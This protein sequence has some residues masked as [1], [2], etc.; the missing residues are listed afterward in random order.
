MRPVLLMAG[1]ISVLGSV[2]AIGAAAPDA[3]APPPGAQVAAAAAQGGR[4]VPGA[5]L[6]ATYCAGCH[7]VDLAGGRA[8]SLFTEKWL[9]AV[10][11][12]QMLAALENG[13]PGTEM[14]SF[15]QN[16]NEAERWQIVQYIRTQA[17]ALA[18]KPAF[19]ADPS[20][21]L[22]RAGREQ[23]KVEVVARDLETPWALAFLPDGRLLVTERPGR[24]RILS[25]GTLSAP[26]AGTPSVHVQQDGGLFDVEVHPLYRANGWIYL[27]YSEVRPGFVP[28]PPGAA[29][30][31][32]APGRGGRGPVIPSMT[33][34]VRGRISPELR[35]MDQEVIYR[36]PL[37]L[38]TPSGSHFGCRMLF[39]QQGRLFFS[40]GER[41]VL[42]DAQDLSKPT[43]KIHRVTDVGGIPADNPF[44]A[45][46]GALP[47]IWSYGHRNPEGLAWDPVSGLLWSSEHGPTGGDEINVIEPGRNYGWGVATKGTQPGITKSS[48]PGMEDPIAYYTPTIGPAGIS[49]YTG[50]T[51]PSWTNTSLF[52]AALAGQQLRRLEIKNR[53]VVSQE[54]IFNQFGRVRDVVQGPDGYFY[55]ALQQPTGAGTGLPLSAS[56]PGLV[57]RLVPQR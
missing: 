33:V 41:G 55:I 5:S 2:L 4:G 19:M 8:P 49:F 14:A 48:E 16:L 6:Y 27:A 46:A 47:S 50:A 15:A 23:L 10:T 38:Y 37:E 7:G 21:Q 51:Y 28:P 25:N 18:P 20:G 1:A 31:T 57:I 13:K 12:E 35:W 43:G 22:V 42:A 24:L 34:I 11:D 53:T 30:E 26:V 44:V 40:L 3:G 9:A 52:V 56:T 45:R 32:P 29:P 54:V 39:D 17:G 36:A